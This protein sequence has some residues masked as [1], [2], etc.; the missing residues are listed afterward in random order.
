MSA[1]MP[2]TGTRG[3]SWKGEPVGQTTVAVLGASGMLGS[4]IVK[5]LSRNPDLRVLATLR[6]PS[7]WEALQSSL[8]SVQWRTLDAEQADDQVIARAVEGA[9]WVVNAIGIIKPYVKDDKPDQVQRAVRVNALFPHLLAAAAEKTGFRVVQIATDCVYSGVKGDYAEG[10]A[11]DAWDVYGK[12]KSLGEVYSPNVFHLRCSIIGPETQAHHSLMDWFLGQPPNGSV[13]GFLNHLWNG[14]TTLQF[15]RLFE[16]IAL[17]Q[18][19]LAHVQHVIPAD[20]IAKADLL[21]SLAE[22]FARPDIAI[23][24]MN[25]SV[26][27]DR[28]LVTAHPQANQDLWKRAGYD[29]PPTTREMVAELAAFCRK[30][31]ART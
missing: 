12:T 1:T 4:M 30:G 7:R 15:A 11:H 3:P 6:N 10:D 19:E 29:Q 8:P 31:E 9:S 26:A 27:V 21:A 22:N 23:N 5:R 28:T 25:A 13:N 16:G 14:V 17:S 24:R 18:P 2:D 20:R